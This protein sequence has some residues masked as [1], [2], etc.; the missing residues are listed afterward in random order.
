MIHWYLILSDADMDKNSKMDILYKEAYY[1]SI[2]SNT[3]SVEDHL[4]PDHLAAPTN[5]QYFHDTEES[6]I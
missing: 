5:N 3:L 6:K 1:K 2:T 4:V